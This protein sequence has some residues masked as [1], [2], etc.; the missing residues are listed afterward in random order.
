MRAVEWLIIKINVKGGAQ[1]AQAADS[2]RIKARD[3]TL[4]CLKRLL[5]FRRARRELLE[6][7]LGKLDGVRIQDHAVPAHD[8]RHSF[9]PQCHAE[10]AR[11][12]CVEHHT[13]NRGSAG[14]SDTPLLARAITGAT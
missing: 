12:A 11:V 9:R 14:P 4:P 1:K 5:V 6:K 8:V 3:S 7:L 10:R 13:F 2:T